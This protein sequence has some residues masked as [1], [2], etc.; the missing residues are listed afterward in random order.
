MRLLLALAL[1]AVLGLTSA[2]GPPAA[3]A[4]PAIL[5]LPPNWVL[6]PVTK[7]IVRLLEFVQWIE[8]D[9]AAQVDHRRRYDPPPIV[10]PALDGV[11]SGGSSTAPDAPPG[12][13]RRG[14]MIP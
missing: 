4:A 3:H 9:L 5:G 14:G 1:A 7:A 8:D 13:V 2:A 11:A 10:V 6:A 12:D